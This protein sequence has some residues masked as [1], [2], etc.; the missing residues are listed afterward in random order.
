MSV[1]GKE[2]DKHLASRSIFSSQ[3]DGDLKDHGSA[4]QSTLASHSYELPTVLGAQIIKLHP[5]FP[6]ASES[7]N[8]HP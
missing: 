6:L 1:H 3:L 7:N 5:Q 8:L 4:M 2:T